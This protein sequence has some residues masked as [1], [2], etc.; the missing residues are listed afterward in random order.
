MQWEMLNEQREGRERKPHTRVTRESHGGDRRACSTAA[1]CSPRCLRLK[2]LERHPKPWVTHSTAEETDSGGCVMGLESHSLCTRVEPSRSWVAWPQETHFG[3][4]RFQ[5]SCLS[6]PSTLAPRA[7]CC[8]SRARP[9][10]HSVHYP[11]CPLGLTLG[12]DLPMPGS[13]QVS[14]LQRGLF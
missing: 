11:C 14:P 2:C 7:S 12:P 6:S 9:L 4:S 1:S 5:S 10:S 3:V 13:V 8:T